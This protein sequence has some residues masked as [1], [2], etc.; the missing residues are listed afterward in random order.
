MA[1]WFKAFQWHE[2]FCHNPEVM[3][4]NPGKVKLGVCIVLMSNQALTK[5]L[6]V[7]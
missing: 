7:I 4:S 6:K 2:M 1:V 5:I 3:G